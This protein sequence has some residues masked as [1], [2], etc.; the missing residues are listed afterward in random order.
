MHKTCVRK[1]FGAKQKK[2]FDCTLMS[3]DGSRARTV[4]A[5]AGGVEALSTHRCCAERNVLEKWI[6]I[7]TKRGVRHH[8]VI[9]WVKRK[10]GGTIIVK[11]VLQDNTP[12][13]SFPCIFCRK[14]LEKYD[15][16]VQCTLRSGDTFEGKL[17]D[18]S[19]P[20]SFLTCGQRR[21]LSTC[22]NSR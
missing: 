14:E 2:E 10:C 13:C 20:Q 12:G 18:P 1:R 5:E 19:L 9:A 8:A 11:R 16:S 22:R 4:H 6:R 21:M 15:I 3:N 7:A 17:D